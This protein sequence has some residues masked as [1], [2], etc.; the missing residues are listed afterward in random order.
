VRIQLTQN[1]VQ[2][3]LTDETITSLLMQYL[4]PRYRAVLKKD[5]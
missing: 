3:E 4:I 2:F 1:D 5:K